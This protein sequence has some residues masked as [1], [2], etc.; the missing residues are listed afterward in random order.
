MK[1][2]LYGAS[3]MIGQRILAEALSRG[4][5]VTAIVRTPSK[6]T[7][8]S[9]HLNV[10]AG[11]I[12]ET[13]EVAKAVVGHDAVVSAY[14]APHDNVAL[15]VDASRSLG[16]GLE[17]AGVKRVISVGGAGSLEVAPGVDLIDSGHLPAEWLAVATA[18]RDALA[19][20]RAEYGKL[21]WTYVSPAAFIQ[22]G[23]RTGKFRLGTDQL[24]TDANGDSRISAEDF[25]VAII[26]ELEKPQFVKR[27]FTVAY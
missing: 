12:L 4:H 15:L 2:A 20:Q 17:A 3:G 22:P 25:A 1:I 5:E 10:L 16:K 18:A 11:D 7:V 19:Y 13:E 8:E 21:D 27:R 24:V 23:E 6:I 9:P 26:D 14:S